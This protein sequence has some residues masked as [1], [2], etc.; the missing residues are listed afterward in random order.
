MSNSIDDKARAVGEEIREEIVKE[1][2]E[3]TIRVLVRKLRKAEYDYAKLFCDQVCT[4]KGKETCKAIRC[5]H[6]LT[7]ERGEYETT[8]D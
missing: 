4:F 3:Y 6:R 5:A 1:A 2:N 8:G 7:I